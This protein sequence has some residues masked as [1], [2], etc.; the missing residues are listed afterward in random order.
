MIAALAIAV[1][2]LAG[3]PDARAEVD[4][5]GQPAGKSPVGAPDQIGAPNRRIDT[6]A[7]PPR[8]Q[9]VD[10]LTAASRSTEAP[11]GPAAG[12]GAAPVA[13][14]NA[15]V[16]S[17]EAPEGP[18]VPQ[19]RRVLLDPVSGRDLCDPA[20]AASQPEV[21]WRTIE[22]RAGEFDL[23]A[24]PEQTLL[25]D[26]ATAGGPDAQAAVRELLT[27]D[28]Q[29]SQAAQAVAARTLRPASSRDPQDLPEA[30]RGAVEAAAAVLGLTAPSGPPTP[31]R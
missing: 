2:L 31:G 13:Q 6:P 20:N 4:Q 7:P 16:R 21:C 30:T 29:T 11:K 23:P 25:A 3:A 15:G 10:Q 17:A 14:V 5:I 19:R 9:Q 27:G 24:T 28:P 12:S 26:T 1:V 18:R 8:A 22:S